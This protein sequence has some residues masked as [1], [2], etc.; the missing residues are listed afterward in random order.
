MEL[1][2]GKL[3]WAGLEIRRHRDETRVEHT[4]K[5]GEELR[6]ELQYMAESDYREN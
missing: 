2:V 4:R 3:T 6:E 5:F 1:V